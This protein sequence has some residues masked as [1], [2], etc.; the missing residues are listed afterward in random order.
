MPHLTAALYRLA[1]AG[2]LPPRTLP[3]A[4]HAHLR[5][6]CPRCDREW[7]DA[8]PRLTEAR[9]RVTADEPPI[10]ADPRAL[11]RRAVEV[12]E[13]RRL[14]R[15]DLLRLL[16]TPP[17]RWPGM[18]SAARSR[19]RSR[20]TVELVVEHGRDLTRSDSFL[21]ERLLAFVP[22]L[23][24]WVPG[25][26]DT[27]WSRDLALRAEARRA[28][29][30]RVAGDLAAADRLFAQVR[31]RL[32]DSSAA[33]PALYA[34]VASLEASLRRDERRYDDALALLD[35]A[36][37]L[38]NECAESVG[39]A[40]TL[41]QRADVL[42]YSDRH[43]EALVDLERARRLIDPDQDPFLYLCIVV[44][45]VPIR[46]SVG[47]PAEAE[48]LLVEARFHAA[49]LEPWWALRLLYLE[50]RA[51]HARGKHDRALRLFAEARRGFV[52]QKLP[53]D[54]AAVSLDVALV[55]LD[56]GDAG[57]A[58]RLAQ[59]IAPIFENVGVERDALATL[60]VLQQATAQ[61]ARRHLAALRQ[62][63]AKAQGKR[64]PTKPARHAG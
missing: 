29:A 63:L 8:E 38:Y 47:R 6:V 46:L 24:L 43:D 21:A 22:E 33:E 34:E 12:R 3:R 5:E 1:L 51:A 49:A 13:A 36:I 28:N 44:A 11:E 35:R 20:A 40:R 15:R 55:H 16:R 31:R 50:G 37:F 58:A 32:V 42:E 7:R 17:E 39:L 52:A 30:L 10:E 9:D 45:E 2:E 14:A 48:R 61:E 62:H 4:L 25:G 19:F 64:G 53:Y 57:Q 41:V 56:R 26:I 18:V 23:L 59:Q 27:A 54:V 60:R